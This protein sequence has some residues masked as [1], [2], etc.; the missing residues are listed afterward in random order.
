MLATMGAQQMQML[1]RSYLVYDI[2]SSAGLLGLVSAS[3][4]LP[5]L[6]LALFGGVVAD[7]MERKRVVQITQVASAVNALFI[8]VSITTDTVTW[9][10][11]LGAALCHGALMSFMMPSRQALIPQ[12]VGQ[13]KLSNAMAL[14]AAGMSAITVLAPAI[15]GIL[16]AF[17]GPGGVYYV[18]VALG[19][20]SVLLTGLLPKL[21]NGPAKSTAPMLSDIKAGLSY[22]SHSPLVL[23][24]LVVGLTTALLAVPFRFLLPVFVVEIYHRGPD[25]MGLLLTV[26]GAGSLVGSLFIA[27]LGRWKRGLLLIAGSFIT[28]MA[29]LGVAVFP[30]YFLALGLMLFLGL[31]EAGRRALNQALVMEVAE[32]RYRGRVWSVFMMNFGLMPLGVLPAGIAVEFLGA[33][34]AI[35]ILAVLLLITA[36]LILVTQKKLRGLQ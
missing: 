20:M 29:L 32:D 26:I 15:A 18:I 36:I 2:T 4:A 23:A 5:V 13:E 24:L 12:L 21:S 16:Y 33:Q 14:N 1:A 11:L 35:G 34:T 30:Y 19:I 7:R 3:N 10:H 8:A 31:G 17:I 27:G 28:G 9:Y 22:I 25:S 6:G